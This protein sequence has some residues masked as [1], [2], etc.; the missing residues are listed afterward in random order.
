MMIESSDDDWMTSVRF[1]TE[2]A[3]RNTGTV[4]FVSVI[5]REASCK[6]GF[7]IAR[8][9]AR[10]SDFGVDRSL[11][12]NF[13]PKCFMTTGLLLFRES[14]LFSVEIYERKLKQ[15]SVLWWG[16]SVIDSD[17]DS[18]SKL[19][20][21]IVLCRTCFHWLWFRFTSLSQMGTVPILGTCPYY[22]HFNQG[23]ME[24]PA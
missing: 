20:G 2:D 19:Y 18:D 24:N 23:K 16:L 11:A 13:S 4:D 9:R 14:R 15:T 21:Y 8:L 17:S 7:C 12:V 6:F 5:S 10:R 1:W 22:I 3:S